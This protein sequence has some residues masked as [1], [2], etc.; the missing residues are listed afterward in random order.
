MLISSPTCP[1]SY[2]VYALPHC[3]ILFRS[4]MVEESGTLESQLEATKVSMPHLFLSCHLGKQ[5][6][7]GALLTISSKLLQDFDSQQRWL[8]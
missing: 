1:L 5:G 2:V 3:D 6:L 7:A 8:G 4:C